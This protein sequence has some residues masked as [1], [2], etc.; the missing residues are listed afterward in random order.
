MISPVRV[1]TAV[2]A[3]FVSSTSPCLILPCTETMSPSLPFHPTFSAHSSNAISL[4]SISRD[5]WGPDAPLL[6]PRL[7]QASIWSPTCFLTLILMCGSQFCQCLQWSLFVFRLHFLCLHNFNLFLS[8]CLSFALNPYFLPS[9]FSSSS[10]L[11]LLP[12]FHLSNSYNADFQNMW[13]RIS[14]WP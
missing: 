8:P 5:L 10:F 7:P 12:S 1:P 6:F 14:V 4:R 2:K 13:V 3:S 11:S 9:L